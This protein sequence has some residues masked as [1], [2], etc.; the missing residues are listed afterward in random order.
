MAKYKIVHYIN[1]FFAGIG[2]EEF[3][4]HEPEI[5]PEVVGPGLAIKKE[6]GDDYEIVATV[7]CG[8]NYFGENLDLATDTIIEMVK[9]YEPD[10]FVA[11]PAFNAGRYG[12]A[13]G[14][15]CKA[16]EE[17]LGVPVITAQYEENPGVD[18]FKRDLIIVKTGPSAAS[19]RKIVPSLGSLIRKLATGEEVLGP[20][21]EGY[22]ERGI[23]MNY[24]AE[25]RGSARAIKVL[26]K[27]MKGEEFHTDLPM[28]K[29]DRVPP[30]DPITD[31]KHAKIA[32]VTSGGIVPTGNPDHIESSNATKFGKY[33]IADMDVMDPDD[34]TTI[35]GGYD[36]QFVMEDPNLVLPLDILRELEKEHEFGE[37]Y[38]YIYTT[39]GTGTSTDSAAKFGT[40]IGK[41]L[42]EKEHIN[43][44]ILVST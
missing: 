20:D 41:E 17:R 40:E 30:A 8:D 6:L 32:L 21:V 16:V 14:T 37:L 35:H 29:F 15:I 1:Q 43:G 44:V 42:V 3:A 34:F 24:F 38:N 4:H 9:D 13:C 22:H 11:G 27:K 7:I 18:M 31:M 23:R 26:V 19:L 5:R 36:R 2:G 28:P 12:V 39:T 33:S 25:E 10:V